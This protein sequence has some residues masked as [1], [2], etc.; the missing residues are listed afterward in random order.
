MEERDQEL[1]VKV[2]DPKSVISLG[3]QV[4]A[5]FLGMA[6][7]IDAVFIHASTVQW[8]VG[9]VL[10]ALVPFEAVVDG[11]RYRN[12]RKFRDHGSDGSDHED[13]S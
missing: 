6:I 11:R 10:F 1:K 12:G 4:I 3:R 9:A 2:E 13:H 8:A 5:V 7:I